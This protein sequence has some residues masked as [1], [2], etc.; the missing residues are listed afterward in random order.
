M[1]DSHKCLFAEGCIVPDYVLSGQ[2]DDVDS[3]RHLFRI[4]FPGLDG[5]G[6]VL[7]ARAFGVPDA[8]ILNDLETLAGDFEANRLDAKPRVGSFGG[9]RG[10][11]R[12]VDPS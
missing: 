4:E 3:L 12:L 2:A 6:P 8:G 7:G 5:A 1:V 9:D 11:R 10:R